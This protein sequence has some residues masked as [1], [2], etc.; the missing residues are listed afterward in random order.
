MKHFLQENDFSSKEIKEIFTHAFA[1]KANRAQRPTNE[2]AGETWGML[3]HKKSTR[4]RV[5]F[6]VGIR[7]L[8]GNPLILDQSS[9]QIGRGESIEDTVKVLSRFLDGLI[10]RTHGHDIIEQFASLGSIPVVN[11]LTDFL[12]P[13]QIFADCM[14]ILEKTGCCQDPYS[15]NG[16]KLTFYGDT[17]CNM[18]NSWIMAGALFGMK[19]RLAGPSEFTPNEQILQYLATHDL[20]TNFEHLTDPIIAARDSD[21][22]YTDVWVSMGCEEEAEQRKRM[23]SPFQVT[24][25]ILQA[26]K[27]GA[28]FMHCMPTHPGEEVS[29]SVLAS[30]QAILFDQAENR[31]HI[32]KAILRQLTQS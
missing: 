18:A 11:A 13:C 25:A 1:Y 14:T 20:P 16:K 2:L 26:S 17:Q 32:Q 21:I 9:T 28:L 5:S 29:E 24:D 31:L 30:P 3:F 23:M 19:I 12:H 6:E 7:E 4:T 15:L 22:L 8:G 27:P 10:I